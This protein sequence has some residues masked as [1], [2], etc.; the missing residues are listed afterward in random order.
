MKDEEKERIRR[1][2]GAANA[3]MLGAFLIATDRSHL[4]RDRARLRE[5]LVRCLELT[6][7]AIASVDG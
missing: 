2:V 1:A 5:R 4:Q 3:E 6:R 7:E